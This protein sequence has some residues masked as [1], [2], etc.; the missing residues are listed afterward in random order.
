MDRNDF[1]IGVADNGANGQ[2][3]ALTNLQKAQDILVLARS[4][5][6]ADREQLMLSIADLCEAGLE[7]DETL[8]PGIE[9][10]VGQIFGDLIQRADRDIRQAL[11]ER[12]ACAPWA[13]HGLIV[14]LCTD[15]IDIARPVI[16]ASP[17]LTSQDL[18]GFLRELALEHQI[19]IARRSGIDAEVVRMILDQ[20]R[21]A[22]LTALAANENADLSD[23]GMARLVDASRDVAALRSPL[24]RH[25]GL[26]EAMA[27]R[28]YVWV[29]ESLRQ[30]LVAR[31][32]EHAQALERLVEHSVTAAWGGAVKSQES[33]RRQMERQLVVKLNDAGQL[34][35]GYLIRVLRE[36]RYTLFLAALAELSALEMEAIEAAIDRDKPELL[37]LACTAAGVDRSAF[38][39]ILALVRQCASGHPTG[40]IGS[41]RR[42]LQAFSVTDPAVAIAAFR[43]AMAPALPLAI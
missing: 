22:V 5:Q 33:D 12:L 39:T 24:V 4:Q 6:G 2:K 18:T 36:Q 25:P 34:K 14:A 1:F 31:Y 11:A 28:L 7:S 27:E 32:P 37:A 13:P 29:G 41:G 8:D 26:T 30:A 3:T 35:P 21:P 43:R 23:G 20:S 40:A 38:S 10:L 15:E 9:A 42:A 17:V 16:G 19:E